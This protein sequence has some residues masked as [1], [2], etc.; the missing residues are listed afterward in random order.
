MPGGERE[1]SDRRSPV[2]FW[3]SLSENVGM[4]GRPSRRAAEIEC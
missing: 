4:L 1:L 2:P 3:L